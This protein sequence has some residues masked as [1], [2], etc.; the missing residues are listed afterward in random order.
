MITKCTDLV[1]LVVELDDAECHWSALDRLNALFRIEELGSVPW[2]NIEG[3]WVCRVHCSIRPSCLT[4]S[5][6]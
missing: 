4:A 3:A 6:I 1:E 2:V 5:S